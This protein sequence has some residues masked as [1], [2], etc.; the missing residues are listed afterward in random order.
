MKSFISI[1]RIL[2]RKVR[3]YPDLKSVSIVLETVVCDANAWNES[4]DEKCEGT[5]PPKHCHVDGCIGV[6]SLRNRPRIFPA[7]YPP[8]AKSNTPIYPYPAE[9]KF[10]YHTSYWV[11]LPHNYCTHIDPPTCMIIFSEPNS[12]H[13]RWAFLSYTTTRFAWRWTPPHFTVTV[14]GRGGSINITRFS[15]DKSWQ[16]AADNNLCSSLISC[17][18]LFLPPTSYLY[19]LPLLDMR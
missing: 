11:L 12:L 2:S 14:T 16:I 10:I 9:R 3:C 6:E 5:F 1:S 7:K 13:L 15:I 19:P 18:Y 8:P 4:D 17:I